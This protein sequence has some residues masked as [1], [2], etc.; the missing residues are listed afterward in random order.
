MIDWLLSIGYFIVVLGI[1]IFIHELGH[2][3]AAKFFGVKVEVFSLGFGRRLFGFRRGET[4]YRVAAIPLGGYVK[5]LGQADLPDEEKAASQTALDRRSYLAKPRW[6]RLIILFAGPAM[7]VVLALVLWWGLF[8]A[9]TQALD[10]PEG[11]PE[12]EAVEAGSPAEAGGLLPGD[13]IVAI[14]GE[15]IASVD[16]YEKIVLFSPG[17]SLDYRIERGTEMVNRPV[18]PGTHPVY[19]V[20]FDGVRIRIP[21][22]VQGVVAGGPADKAGFR[23]G[24]RILEVNGRIPGGISAVAKL[25]EE[26]EGKPVQITLLRDGAESTVEVVPQVAEG[27]RAR[28]GVML[29]WPTK[30][31]RYGPVR[32]ASESVKRAWHDAG[33]LFETL[34]KLVTGAVGLQVMS[35]PIEIARVSKEQASLGLQPFLNFLAF[36]SLQLGIFNLLPIP[37][38]DGGHMLMLASEAVM[39]RDLSLRI[40]ER[41]LQVGFVFL[42][43]FALSVIALDVL[44]LSRRAGSANPPPAAEAPANP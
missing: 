13:R 33:L 29:S 24:D 22:L 10:I 38:L 25:V 44:K 28:I 21:I 34:S 37:V 5:M 30:T 39:R 8:T 36:V 2:F 43:L 11:P 35:G 31:V 12:V 41:V 14:A 19:G 6:Q 3:L 7:N 9:G 26:F 23:A 27:G 42:V 16:D 32:A 40:K 4:D 20:G 18:T 15:P 17:R 1:L